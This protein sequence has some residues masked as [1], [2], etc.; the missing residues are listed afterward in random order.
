MREGNIKLIEGAREGFVE[1]EGVPDMVLEIISDSSVKMDTK[2]LP[3]LYWE[4]GIKEYWL[5]DVRGQRLS[6]D[7]F[8][9][10]SRGYVT[11]KKPGG[12]LRSAVFDRSFRL[13]R[14]ED[15]FDNP[16]DTLDVK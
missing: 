10:T 9:S 8:R 16:Q 2:R 11:T 7:I 4:A 14:G 12:W 1:V 3:K 6:F 5:V 13:T 15:A